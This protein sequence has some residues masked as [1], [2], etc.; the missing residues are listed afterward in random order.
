MAMVTCFECRE[1][2]SGAAPSCP[3]CGAKQP[4]T[5][6]WLWVPLAILAAFFLLGV[7]VG[8][9]PE[10]KAK[11]RARDGIAYC[12]REQERSSLS[13]GSQ[14]FMASACEQMEKEFEEKYGI[15]P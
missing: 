13:P 8:N 1:E 10:A 6:W 5:K 4:R 7:T 12:R 14:Q 3:K 15:S 2:I 9:S 11:A